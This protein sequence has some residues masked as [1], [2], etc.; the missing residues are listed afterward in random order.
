MKP[1]N[2]SKK[3]IKQTHLFVISETK[4]PSIRRWHKRF[5][6]HIGGKNVGY[7]IVARQTIP[8]NTPYRAIKIKEDPG[9]NYTIQAFYVSPEHRRNGYGTTLMNHVKSEYPRK[10]IVLRPKPYEERRGKIRANKPSMTMYQLKALYRKAGFRKSPRDDDIMVQR[11]SK[12][13]HKNVRQQIG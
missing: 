13:T 9:D 5:D 4:D 7:I 11:T 10:R 6:M 2:F 8:D 3:I 12:E 1:Q